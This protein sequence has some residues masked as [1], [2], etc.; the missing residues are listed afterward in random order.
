MM[1]APVV[2]DPLWLWLAACRD[3]GRVGDEGV[4]RE[5]AQGEGE[6]EGGAN[7]GGDAAGWG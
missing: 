4:Q 6:G 3:D 5:A 7:G 1:D 2:S